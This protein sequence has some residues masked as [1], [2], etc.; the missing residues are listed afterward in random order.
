MM[1]ARKW[2]LGVIS[3]LS[4]FLLVANAPA[5]ET[6]ATLRGGVDIMELPSAPVMT[7][8]SNT[9]LRQS[10]NYPEQPPT[11]PHKT[12][13]YDIDLNS[14][15]CMSC[16]SRT[17]V[18]RSQAPMISVTHFMDADNQVLT[19]VAARRYFCNQCH[20]PSYGSRLLVGNTFVDVETLIKK[21]N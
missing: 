11:I 13:G 9:S 3:G 20:V 6:I 5:G 14:N 19:S 21:G 17:A 8:Q 10:R 15:K 12:R 7:R 1:T 18:E 2:A 16:H 4:V